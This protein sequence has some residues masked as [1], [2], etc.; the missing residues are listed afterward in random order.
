M[1]DADAVSKPPCLAWHNDRK[2]EH[3]SH[4]NVVTARV[5][6]VVAGCLYPIIF[7]L[8]FTVFKYIDI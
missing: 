1:I 3:D 7:D 6:Y 4:S 2:L 5:I 8:S